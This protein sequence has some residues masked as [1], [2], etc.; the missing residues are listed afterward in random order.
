MAYLEAEAEKIP[1]DVACYPV[2]RR[3]LSSAPAVVRMRPHRKRR[4]EETHYVR[5]PLASF[6]IEGLIESCCP[7]QPEC[8]PASA[9]AA[10]AHVGLWHFATRPST[11]FTLAFKGSWGHTPRCSLNRENVENDPLRQSGGPKCCDAHKDNP[12]HVTVFEIYRD[13]EAHLAHLQTPHFLK[14][15]AMVEKMV[16]NLQTVDVAQVLPHPNVGIC[17]S[18][19]RWTM[20]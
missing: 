11:V 15:K 2:R 6:E 13:R 19:K 1:S 12:A 9:I 5:I 14:Y 16:N 3:A 10:S 7:S 4:R 18:F 20:R 8:L 17:F